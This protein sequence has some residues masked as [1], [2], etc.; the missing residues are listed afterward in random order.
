MLTVN[1]LFK[2]DVQ[3]AEES[4][5]RLP[6]SVGSLKKQDSS[7][8]VFISAV[9][10]M[11]KLLLHGLQKILENSE[12]DGNIRPSDLPLKKSVCTSGNNSYNWTCNRLVANRKRHTSKLYFVSL[13]I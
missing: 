6:T 5:I 10:T 12:R 9:L 8:K 11:L 7:R 13:L 1:F 3:K 4:E 2:L